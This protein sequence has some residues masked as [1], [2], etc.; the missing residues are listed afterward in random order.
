MFTGSDFFLYYT[1]FSCMMAS[2]DR[3]RI[4]KVDIFFVQYY[5]AFTKR[6]RLKKIEDGINDKEIIHLTLYPNILFHILFLGGLFAR[7]LFD[8]LAYP[9]P[10]YGRLKVPYERVKTSYEWGKI[11][12]GRVNT[13]YEGVNIPYE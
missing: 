3:I 1:R 13:Q 2:R 8:I 12:Y 4:K 6:E 7:I 5:S 10:S 9:L 11:Q